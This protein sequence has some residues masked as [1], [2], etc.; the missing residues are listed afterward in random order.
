VP[1]PDRLA[2]LADVELA[3][4]RE[5][6]LVHAKYRNA[7]DVRIDLHLDDVRE[8]VLP[9][10]GRGGHLGGG[11]AGIDVEVDGRVSFGRVGQQS[12]DHVEQLG[13]SRSAACRRE[14]HRDQMPLA[15]CALERVVELLRLDF[16]F[17]EIDFHQLFVD[18]D[19]LVDELAV[20]LLDR[21]KIRLA[22]R[23][24]EAVGDPGCASR[25]EVQRQALLAERRL[26]LVE[27]PGKVD[28]LGVDL[29]DDDQAVEPAL[30][31]PLHEAAGHHLDAVLRVD[32]DRRGLD[33]SERGQRVAEKVRV[34]RR[35]EQVDAVPRVRALRLEG[36]DRHLQRMAD[37][38]F[39]R[40][41]VAD[42]SAA[43]DAARRRDRPRAHEQRLGERGLSGPRLADERNRPD[44]FGGMLA[45]ECSSG[46]LR[47]L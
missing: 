20:R 41:V 11:A 15:Q 25:R 43:L 17:L 47:D 30:A 1:G 21:G 44:V 35:V 7:S 28:I 14:H 3:S 2:A 45:H 13:D 8:R 39:Q 19:H 32:H 31:R 6:P 34:A 5:A 36:R 24:E 46:I 23:R 37:R 27:Q 16:A 9:R 12:H 22:G 26:D 4:R 18:L 40:L 42:G 33:R 29:V 10:L 38:F